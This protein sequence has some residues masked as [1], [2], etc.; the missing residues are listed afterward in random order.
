MRTL[1]E[2]LTITRAGDSTFTT[3]IPDGWQ[4][5]RGAFGGLVLGL[6]GDAM[7]QSEPDPERPLRTLSGE[8]LAP[9]LPEP[10]ELRVEVLRR[11][12]GLSS[13]AARLWQSGEV[14]A[15]A[16]ALFGKTRLSD[17]EHT[18][19]IPPAPRAWEDLEEL[20]VAPPFG[21]DFARAF[22]YRSAGPLPF[23]GST[24]L[25]TDGFIRA[26]GALTRLGAPQLVAYIDAWWPSVYGN[27]E[28]PRP[29]ATVSFTFQLMIDPKTLAPD[30]RLRFRAVA[31]AAHDGYVAEKRELWTTDGRLVALNPQTFVYIR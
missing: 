4:Q 3:E 31:E 21:P 11:G 12:S 29:M 26:K 30:A 14:R 24:A 9:V 20:P 13:L 16:T 22:E 1:G 15:H 17:R 6:L 28:L 25:A 8:I 23:S 27:E 10:A 5:G 7:E 19:L 18:G 2:A